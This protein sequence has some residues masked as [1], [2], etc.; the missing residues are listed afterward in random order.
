MLGFNTP[1]PGGTLTEEFETRV[2]TSDTQLQTSGLL[3]GTRVATA[4]GWRA[5]EEIVP[6]DKVL[7]F[8]G[9][10]QEVQ[11]VNRSRAW[12]VPA[13]C[14]RDE[15]PLLVP[16][17]ALGNREPVYLL[18]QQI[19]LVESDTAEEM[20]GDPFALIPAAAM[21][22]VRGI[23]RVNPQ[24]ILEVVRIEF[25]QDQ[26]VF[27]N[28]GALFFCPSRVQADL[29]QNAMDYSVLPLVEACLLAEAMVF[30]DQ[31]EVN[32]CVT[33]VGGVAEAA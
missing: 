31:G 9:G 24:Q 32:F 7:T 10:M 8:D 22:G 16:Q 4:A 3:S 13:S 2:A 17:G 15:W 33:D 1:V 18:A 30:E 29:S 19:V 27:A 28:I 12:A 26:V 6:G 23:K 11:S 5:V 20:F 14:P 25:A 21:E